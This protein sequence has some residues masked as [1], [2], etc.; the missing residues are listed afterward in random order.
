LDES[1]PVC[2]RWSGDHPALP[3]RTALSIPPG[4]A[5]GQRINP[6]WFGFPQ[7]ESGVIEDQ[8]VDVGVY[9][10]GLQRAA[11]L[12]LDGNGLH[13][14]VGPAVLCFGVDDLGETVGS[15]GGVAIS[16]RNNLGAGNSFV[17]HNHAL[18]CAYLSAWKGL[19]IVYHR[20]EKCQG[21]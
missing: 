18:L 4:K 10:L 20:V 19:T 21:W 9:D 5:D 12:F 8:H 1:K 17:I 15:A 2:K 7:A 11:G 3:V 14:V 13:G 6:Y 16:D